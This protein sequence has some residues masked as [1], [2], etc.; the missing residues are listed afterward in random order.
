MGNKSGAL[1]SS[2][3]CRIQTLLAPP[4]FTLIEGESIH[5]AEGNFVL[6]VH[7]FTRGPENR[8]RCVMKG[9]IWWLLLVTLVASLALFTACDQLLDEEEDGDGVIGPVDE[10]AVGQ[11]LCFGGPDYGDDVYEYWAGLLL[12]SDGT[13]THYSYIE[14]EG[15]NDFSAEA[16]YWTAEN[17]NCHVEM[18][19]SSETFDMSYA[20]TLDNNLLTFF[21]VDNEGNDEIYVRITNDQDTA[22]LGSWMVT[23]PANDVGA[24]ITLEANGDGSYESPGGDDSND[25]AWFSTNGYIGIIMYQ[26]VA[27]MA[28]S[29]YVDGDEVTLEDYEGNSMVLQRYT[30]GTTGEVVDELVGSW[31]GY[32]MSEN[33]DE[34]SGSAKLKSPVP[35]SSTQEDDY[36]RGVTFVF[37]D[38]GTGSIVMLEEEDDEDVVNTV[39]VTWGGVVDGVILME[40]E[41][42][43]ED[44][45]IM[46]GYETNGD[47]LYLEIPEMFEDP[48]F[49]FT[50]FYWTDERPSDYYG[51]F[52][53][54][55]MHFG[56]IEMPNMH[57]MMTLVLEADGGVMYQKS[58]HWDDYSQEHYESEDADEFIWCIS[59][60]HFV[61]VDPETMLGEVI[62]FDFEEMDGSARLGVLGYEWIY[63]EIVEIYTEFYRFS[64]ANDANALGFWIA[65]GQIDDVQNQVPTEP[66]NVELLSDGSGRTIEMM[67]DE[68]SMEDVV[69]EN[70]FTWHTVGEMLLVLHDGEIPCGEAIGYSVEDNFLDVY[71]LSSGDSWEQLF[72]YKT[73]ELDEDVYGSW[74]L[75][76]FYE[77]G[78]SQDVDPNSALDLINDG[79][80]SHSHTDYDTGTSV[81]VEYFDWSVSEGYVLI[82]MEEPDSEPA[83]D[84]HMAMEYGV[85]GTLSYLT[86]TSYDFD[87]DSDVIT[88]YVEVYQRVE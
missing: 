64:G 5:R 24:I 20:L 35:A 85:D 54:T 76:E 61:H 4:T 32:W 49:T 84:L 60:D 41:S 31:I 42:E 71:S 16:L 12:N 78:I 28:M 13:G 44:V 21:N 3:Y 73:G 87:S 50:C 56:D 1:S 63:D 79:T 29:Y 9:K 62:Q 17:G 33:D 48:A 11:W 15:G 10:A 68:D 82:D 59:G 38:D 47:V 18:V 39:P 40:F 26:G 52:I 6:P 69:Q 36:V 14:Y 65:Y 23:S 74:T 45:S 55:S 19:N 75:L 46:V 43:G 27:G 70:H 66:V 86:I 30:G 8:E 80:G 7:S 81:V 37:E 72:V 34:A 53:M 58:E 67:Y 2:I 88:T 77:D 51:T 83:N 22:L 57:T 25:F